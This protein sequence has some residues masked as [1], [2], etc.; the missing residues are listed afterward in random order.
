MGTVGLPVAH[1]TDPGVTT[2]LI[3]PDKPISAATVPLLGHF[4]NELP[5]RAQKLNCAVTI[6]LD[7]YSHVLPNM[8]DELAGAVANLLERN[9]SVD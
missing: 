8:Q 6:T 7:L 9:A 1:S 3:S 2:W 5:S 4:S